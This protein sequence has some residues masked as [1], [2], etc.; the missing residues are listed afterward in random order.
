MHP[1]RTFAPTAAESKLSG[2]DFDGDMAVLIDGLMVWMMGARR[3]RLTL[4]PTTVMI[5]SRRGRALH[6]SWEEVLDVYTDSRDTS[7]RRYGWMHVGV[8]MTAD[9]LGHDMPGAP[10]FADEE[11]NRHAS[12][13]KVDAKVAL[14]RRYRE[15][16]VG[17]WP[18]T[19]GA[20]GPSSRT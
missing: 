10:G 15:L 16:M 3:R 19:P 1:S 9:G 2:V 5:R 6:Y 14:V 7:T 8:L 12:A 11:G 13:R 17:P 18:P 20:P 4:S